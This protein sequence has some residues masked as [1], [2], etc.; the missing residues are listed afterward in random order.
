MD[1]FKTVRTMII[2]NDTSYNDAKRALPDSDEIYGLD[3]FK[4]AIAGIKEEIATHPDSLWIFCFLG[5][6][7]ESYNGQFYQAILPL[8]E[9]EHTLMFFLAYR[10]YHL[11]C[12]GSPLRHSITLCEGVAPVLDDC[13][14]GINAHFNSLSSTSPT[15]ATSEAFDQLVELYM[16][17]EQI[18]LDLDM[19]RLT[20]LIEHCY[21]S[22][23][24]HIESDHE[25]PLADYV[26]FDIV[27]RMIQQQQPAVIRLATIAE[28]NLAYNML[29][30]ALERHNFTKVKLAVALFDSSSIE[31]FK[32]T[33]ES[34]EKLNK[35]LDWSP[36]SLADFVNLPCLIVYAGP[37]NDFAL[38]EYPLFSSI[39]MRLIM[40]GYFTRLDLE[41]EF[42]L[43][44]SYN[45]QKSMASRTTAEWQAIQALQGLGQG[46]RKG[47]ETP[48]DDESQRKKIKVEHEQDEEDKTYTPTKVI[49]SSEAYALFRHSSDLSYTQIIPSTECEWAPNR[50]FNLTRKNTL[51]ELVDHYAKNCKS[52][53][54]YGNGFG[55]TSRRFVVSVSHCIK[56][57]TV[58]RE[59]TR[60]IE[61][62]I[63][64]QFTVDVFDE[65][66]IDVHTTQPNLS[67]TKRDQLFYSPILNSIPSSQLDSYTRQRELYRGQPLQSYNVELSH[68]SM[69]PSRGRKRTDSPHAVWPLSLNVPQLSNGHNVQVWLWLWFDKILKTL[70]DRSKW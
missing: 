59:I 46:K 65:T 63:R 14:Y 30:S 50:H 52:M 19:V 54:N 40:N 24:Y 58:A 20:T 28:G 55:A 6:S 33:A 18:R 21:V 2:V 11:F 49:L 9:D 70:I 25:T 56:Q 32:M 17:E 57:T 5:V 4:H 23:F 44:T 1:Q 15:V 61:Q 51:S 36:V 43:A 31:P 66:E 29:K 60:E 64:S 42:L 7:H 12:D 45:K 41:R 10:P 38:F 69:V 35:P 16:K 34:K 47:D 48:D 3:V 62:K 67:L 8:L 68:L 22:T 37:I 27:N 26:S 53:L 13:E 39:D